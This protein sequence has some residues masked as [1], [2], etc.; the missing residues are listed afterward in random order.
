MRRIS[1]LASL[2]VATSVMSAAVYAGGWAVVTLD[3]LP[4]SLVV[5]KPT[6]LGFVVRQHGMT[7]V[8]GLR[9]VVEAV[10]G[11]DRVTAAAEPG[12]RP[13]HYLATL[14]VPRAGDWV[15]TVN[16]GFGQSR[17]TLLP[18]RAVA[19][20]QGAPDLP[21]AERGRR[22]FLAKG[23]V[24]CHQNTLATANDSTGI[25]PLL[26]PQKYQAVFL[27]RILA[28]PSGTLPPRGQV[29]ATMPNLD[30]QPQEIAALVAFINTGTVTASR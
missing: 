14:T 2:A 30:L 26:I 28:D 15:I 18:T 21:A 4:D 9:P 19:A 5:G 25:G 1:L 13:G 29:G 27:A 23:C 10:L 3:T 24:T 17:L 20:A 6:A 12:D 22:L 7:P 16:S 11:G 8:G